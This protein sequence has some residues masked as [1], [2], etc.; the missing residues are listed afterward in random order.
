MDIISKFKSD[1]FN[2]YQFILEKNKIYG[3]LF[4]DYFEDD[5]KSCYIL[6]SD[7]DIPVIEIKVKSL[8]LANAAAYLLDI[9]TFIKEKEVKL[10]EDYYVWKKVTIISNNNLH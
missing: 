5:G 8:G 9:I 2:N 1:F 6:Y 10:Y 3:G 7:F 4:L